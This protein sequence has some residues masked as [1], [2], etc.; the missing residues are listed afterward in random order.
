M[1]TDAVFEFHC[2]QCQHRL[3][4]SLSVVGRRGKC[5]KCQQSFAVPSLPKAS[6]P[7]PVEEDDWSRLGAPA[8]ADLSA[9]QEWVEA[10][11]ATKERQ[12]LAQIN[13][14]QQRRQ[15]TAGT[16]S[17]PTDQEQVRELKGT[18]H[19]PQ[20]GA[21][22]HDHDHDGF[23]LAPLETRGRTA[24]AQSAPVHSSSQPTGELRSRPTTN[25]SASQPQRTQSN[26]HNAAGAHHAA[27]Q[28]SPR[29]SI[30]DEDLPELAQLQPNSKPSKQENELLAEHAG[31]AP[32]ELSSLDDLVPD[33]GAPPTSHRPSRSSSGSNGRSSSTTPI[34]K[35]DKDPEYRITCN[36]CGTAQ[37]VRMS[38]K[39]KSIKCPD[40]Y[41]QF[42]IPGPP[43][44]WK[45]VAEKSSPPTDE[46]RPS[47]SSDGLQPS[48][49]QERQ[50]DRTAR[51]L[52]QAQQQVTD[53]DLERLY[54][55]DFDT[56]NFL[57][58]T[59]GF[60]KDPV[61]L[62]HVIG[63]AIVFAGIFAVAQFAVLYQDTR[64]GRS[65]LLAI[66][67][68]A[69]AI[70]ILF[71]MPMLSSC[72]A[73][74]ESVANRQRRVADWPG[75]NL[76]ENA[77]DV[78]AISSALL[79][80]MMPGFL[81]GSWLGGEGEGSGRIQIAGMMLS[82]F[83]LFPVFL[84]SMLDNGSVFAPWSNSIFRSFTEA[85]EAW[86]GYFLKT[87]IAFAI[88]LLLWLLL[89]GAGKPIA[90]AACA[91]SLFPPLVYFT[92][93]QIGA[94]ADSI[95]EHLSIELGH[96]SEPDSDQEAELSAAESGRRDVKA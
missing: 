3:K 72:I 73:L 7:K 66:A 87:L 75:F 40:C 68:G 20:A 21:E 30:F 57:Q 55:T 43:L 2:P 78:A 26:A 10:N 36:A 82:S 93:Q 54:D 77:G 70:G 96:S 34:P 85:T 79:G 94:L 58:R 52:E 76:L 23:R 9:R 4:A 25:A 13:K 29:R 59:F 35:V 31:V 12:R 51:M 74:I 56:A 80:A 64:L 19:R 69:P 15:S 90:M 65:A 5:P 95:G 42:K 39:G 28:A 81:L 41:L 33:L 61:A 17:T 86:G 38:Q 84:L 22:D 1:P 24:P 67:I 46:R 14:Q 32:H 6:E 45:P 44:G 62:A 18:G 27:N 71:S 63:Y 47:N 89:L 16:T 91:G 48:E 60:L 53:D 11:R 49:S 83:A 8:I 50:R 92:C 37:Y 88:V